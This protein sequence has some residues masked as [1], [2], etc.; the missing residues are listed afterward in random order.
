MEIGNDNCDNAK[1]WVIPRSG[2]NITVRDVLRPFSR[3]RGVGLRAGFADEMFKFA[4][5][6][7]KF[8]DEIYKFADRNTNLPTIH[9]NLPTITQNYR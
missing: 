5:G 4:D 3:G 1:N 6:T 2:G 7:S 8:A 9:A